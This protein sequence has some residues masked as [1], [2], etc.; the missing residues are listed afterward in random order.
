M[1]SVIKEFQQV[2]PASVHQYYWTS[3]SVFR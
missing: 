1:S 3:A 2:T